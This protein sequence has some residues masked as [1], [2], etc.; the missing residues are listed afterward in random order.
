MHNDPSLA[1]RCPTADGMLGRDLVAAELSRA[2]DPVSVVT[3]RAS[4]VASTPPL[5]RM[6]LGDVGAEASSEEPAR[7]RT[8][9]G[10]RLRS[11]KITWNSF[12][13]PTVNLGP[14]EIVLQ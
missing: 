4:E 2:V 10:E 6:K 13:V 3:A 8:A 1:R 5:P 11:C 7:F 9:A 12:S 14:N